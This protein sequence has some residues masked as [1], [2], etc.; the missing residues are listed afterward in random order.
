VR[1]WAALLGL[2]ALAGCAPTLTPTGALATS[3][4]VPPSVGP[5]PT[6]V[7][8]ACRAGEVGAGAVWWAGATAEMAGGFALYDLGPESCTIGGRV[9]VELRD[10]FGKPLA[11]DVRQL[12]APEPDPVVLLPGLGTPTLD[13][14]AVGGRAGVQVFWVNWCGADR[15]ATGRLVVTI[16]GV[17]A[18]I[19]SAFDL[20]PPRCDAPGAHSTMSIGP[21]VPQ[22]AP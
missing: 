2:V 22:L 17:G 12:D 16:P 5:T 15:S 8:R 19:T 7:V 21:I 3:S 1:T 14:G 9:A 13:D 6:P 4:P 18:L 20:H 11:I 10:A